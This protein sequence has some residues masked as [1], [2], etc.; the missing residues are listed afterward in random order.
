ML[1]RLRGAV[2][3]ICTE[4][5]E[6]SSSLQLPT[7]LGPSA[8][9]P[10]G[11]RDA[12]VEEAELR[13]TERPARRFAVPNGVR[14]LSQRPV[15]RPLTP[16]ALVWCV[17]KI[18]SAIATVLLFTSMRPESGVPMVATISVIHRCSQQAVG[19][20]IFWAQRVGRGPLAE[21]PASM[22]Y[23]TG[24]VSSSPCEFRELRPAAL[25]LGLEFA[26]EQLRDKCTFSLVHGRQCR[27][28]HRPLRKAH[29]WTH[30]L[31][32]DPDSFC[33]REWVEN[34]LR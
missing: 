15:L 29:L 32:Q 23:S 28:S 10:Q 1:H 31:C 2:L 30:G 27:A 7:R 19:S 34:R 24:D 21:N 13:C 12:N 26:K 25:F 6:L 33:C 16:S 22:L 4:L 18:T 8:A 20:S 9:P 5:S 14:I 11:Q 3:L 17:S